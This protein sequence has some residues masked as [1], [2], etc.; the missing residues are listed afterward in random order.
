[1]HI[2]LSPDALAPLVDAIADAVVER[3]REA[4]HDHG[5]GRIAY[6]EAEAAALVGLEPHVLREQRRLG[7]ITPC[8]AR[9]GRRILYSRRA[10]EDFLAARH[11]QANGRQS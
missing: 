11:A 5:D 3:L 10:I 9:P 6:S 2:D 1:M 7:R 8:A 4:R